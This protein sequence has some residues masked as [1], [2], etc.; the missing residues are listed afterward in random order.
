MSENKT[1]EASDVIVRLKMIHSIIQFYHLFKSSNSYY[2][3]ETDSN[4]RNKLI[5]E[6]EISDFIQR[7][8]T[9]PSLVLSEKKTP[10][11]YSSFH[12]GVTIQIHTTSS[13]FF[14]TQIAMEQINS[15]DSSLT[16]TI[17]IIV[18]YNVCP[19]WA[20]FKGFAPSENPEYF[21]IYDVKYLRHEDFQ[22][23]VDTLELLK[24]EFK[25]LNVMMLRRFI[26]IK[27]ENILMTN[28]INHSSKGK[29]I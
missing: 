20:E 6:K 15:A 3:I 2:K 22:D 9:D 18:I 24:N 27:D 26:G 14:R 8:T 21:R 28:E 7:A 5:I 1:Y 16:N 29:K 23:N 13:L 19:W 10:S 25:K 17:K 11:V 4:F 12:E